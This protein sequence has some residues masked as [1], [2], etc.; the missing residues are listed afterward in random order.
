MSISAQ[1][2][3]APLNLDHYSDGLL[4]NLSG[5]GGSTLSLK[6]LAQL[7]MTHLSQ[8]QITDFDDQRAIMGEIKKALIKPKEQ[9]K[10]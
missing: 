6:K 3:L 5:D 10:R 9:S 8:M 1:D 7:R 4:L 2:L